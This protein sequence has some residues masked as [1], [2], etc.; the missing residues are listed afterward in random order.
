VAELVE[1]DQHTQSNQ[2]ADNHVKRTHLISPQSNPV[3][4]GSSAPTD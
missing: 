2:G 4:E 3:P 1:G